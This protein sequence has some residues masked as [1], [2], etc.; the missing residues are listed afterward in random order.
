MV[1]THRIY[2]HSITSS[3]SRRDLCLKIFQISSFQ[4]RMSLD[5]EMMPSILI[6][7]TGFHIRASR[8]VH[9]SWTRPGRVSLSNLASET[10]H[11]LS[12][13]LH[14]V[15]LIIRCK[16]SVYHRPCIP[17][18]LHL[19]TMGYIPQHALDNLKKYS[20]KGVDK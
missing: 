17:Q 2:H 11:I 5:L 12:D 10:I 16:Q 20:Y 7:H 13:T 4:I 9:Q 19:D 6:R 18:N 3:I 8:Q 15:L 14:V 1:S